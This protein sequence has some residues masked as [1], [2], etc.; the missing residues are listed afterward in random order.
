MDDA[1]H[2]CFS[3]IHLFGRFMTFI[4]PSDV[5]DSSL[6]SMNRSFEARAGHGKMLDAE[7]VTTEARKVRPKS[8]DTKARRWV[9]RRTL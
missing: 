5:T 6:L 4:E 1:Q 2:G 8:E 9:R 7:T 3:S